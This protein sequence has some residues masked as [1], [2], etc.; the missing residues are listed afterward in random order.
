MALAIGAILALLAF[1]VAIYPFIGRRFLAGE[2]RPEAEEV[3]G[4]SPET[5]ERAYSAAEELDSI[6]QAIRTLQLERQ[7]GS[8]PE[9]L[10][11][12]QLN[13][14]RLQAAQILRASEESLN[15]N[16][17]S[18]LEEEIRL[19]RAGIFQPGG[20]EAVCPNCARP[21]SKEGDSCP[22]CGVG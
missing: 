11:R 1:A 20:S 21:I 19:A 13:A 8:V 16:S 9:G 7:L 3:E 17:D 18:A 6:Y 14:Y 12:E 10:Y 4:N 2:D 5:N 22:E 15:M